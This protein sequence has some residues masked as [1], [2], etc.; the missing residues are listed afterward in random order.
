[1][2]HFSIPYFIKLKSKEQSLQDLFCESSLMIT[3]YSSVAF[4][5]AY[6]GKSVLYYQFDEKEFFAKHHCAKGYFDYNKNGFGPVVNEEKALF[7]ELENLL[8]NDC[9][10]KEPYKSNIKNT[11]EFKDN[12]NCARIYKE[13]MSL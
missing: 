5:M 9:K 4:E 2:K 12:H 7:K 3:D 10:A 1:M 11:F 13:I 6:L 8:A